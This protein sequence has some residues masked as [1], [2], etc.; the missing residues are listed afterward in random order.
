[1]LSPSLRKA[2]VLISALDERT[3]DAVLQQMSTEDAAKVR[4]ALIELDEIPADEQQ[5]VLVEF[6]R[7]QNAPASPA[8]N[9]GVEV[10]LEIDPQLEQAAGAI[11]FSAPPETNRDEPS[12]DFLQHVDPKA[13]ATVL[14]GEHPQTV[15]V[16]VA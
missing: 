9:D 13:L 12:F 7:Q 8:A 10:L 11:F 1:M 5:Q 2:A 15:A 6:F 16:V 3:A 14:R 4:S